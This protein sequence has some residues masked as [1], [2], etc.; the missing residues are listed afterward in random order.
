MLNIVAIWSVLTNYNKIYDRIIIN[1]KILYVYL[2]FEL[3]LID[4]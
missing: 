1:L 2:L 4:I 3:Y